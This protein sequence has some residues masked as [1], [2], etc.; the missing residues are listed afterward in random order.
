MLYLIN[1]GPD[2]PFGGGVPGVGF[3][4]PTPH[5]TGQVM[6]FRRRRSRA[7]GPQPSIP[8]P[9]ALVPPV[10]ARRRPESVQ[11]P[12]GVAQRGGLG[13][14]RGRRARSGGARHAGRA[15]AM[16]LQLMW[17][18]DDH[19]EPGLSAT[20]IWEIYNFTADAHPIHIHEVQF[21]V[22]NR[23][24]LRPEVPCRSSVRPPEAWETGFKDTVIAY[25]GEITRIKAMFDLPGR[26]RLA[27]PHR[28][29][30]GQ[31]DDA[32][33]RRRAGPCSET[34]SRRARKASRGPGGPGPLSLPANSPPARLASPT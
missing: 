20:E 13:G 14:S 23:Q 12:P 34:I 27:L 4:P 11:D 33:L 3:P 2:E 5:T 24:G 22:V 16:P 28:G 19:R 15:P 18:D 1:E 6:K 21:Q 17:E 8:L 31:R 9:L 26:Y 10:R 7:S 32:P 25:P 29:T 30:R